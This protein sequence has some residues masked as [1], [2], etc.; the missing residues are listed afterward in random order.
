VRTLFEEFSWKASQWTESVFQILNDATF[1]NTYHANH[2]VKEQ[3][4][5][6]FGTKSEQ[7]QLID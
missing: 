1:S 3:I 6:Y 2:Q 4:G 7:N 5:K